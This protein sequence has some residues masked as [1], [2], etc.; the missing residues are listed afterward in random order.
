MESD[1]TPPNRITPLRPEPIIDAAALGTLLEQLR[2]APRLALD[3]EFMRERTYYAELA[4]LQIADLRAVHLIDPLADLPMATLGALL[5]TPGQTKVLHAGR[6]D[7]EVLL[8]LTQTPITPLFDTQVAAALLGYAPQVG[9]AD[10]LARELGVLL[11]KT[12]SRTDWMRRPLTEA[13]LDYAADDVRWLLP[14][15]SQLEQ[16]LSVLGRGTWLAEEMARLAEPQTYQVD[17][18]TAWQRLKGVESL[19]PQEQLRIRTLAACRET[20]AVRRNLP[21]GWVMTDDALRTIARQPPKDLAALTALNVLA[22]GAAQKMAEEILAAL[23]AAAAMS[24]AGITQQLET[25]PSAAERALTQA[26][27]S[28]VKDVGSRLGIA[29]ELLAPGRDL[30]RLARGDAL[31]SVLRGWR[32]AELGDPLTTVLSAHQ[33][34]ATPER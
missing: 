4:L 32:L 6:Q 14:L 28:C 17:A 26:L 29:P 15:A 22:P 18:E 2:E 20:R 33:R 23:D 8:P 21:R 1:C 3:T 11:A 19:P 5:T 25:R 34:A 10:L 16:K 9:Y 13:Q 24:T 30:R 27:S 12:Q 7:I 31:T